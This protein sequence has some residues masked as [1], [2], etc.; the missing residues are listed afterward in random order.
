MVDVLAS[1]GNRSG[2]YAVAV[3]RSPAS[4][5]RPRDLSAMLKA[6]AARQGLITW[7]RRPALGPR[8]SATVGEPKFIENREVVGSDDRDQIA[9]K[10][11]HRRRGTGPISSV[12][13]DHGQIE[14]LRSLLAESP[15]CH[16][17]MFGF[18]LS[19]SGSD[20]GGVEVREVASSNIVT[21]SSRL[22]GIRRRK[23]GG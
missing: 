3:R 13:R 7:R 14:V 10:M 16:G 15:G 18:L 23:R 12:G 2:G 22:P 1:R 11:M 8:A 19:E 9:G 20:M 4:S 17:P 5:D 21:Q 6:A